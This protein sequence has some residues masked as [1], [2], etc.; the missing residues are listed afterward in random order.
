MLIPSDIPNGQVAEVNLFEL[1]SVIAQSNNQTTMT[2][3]CVSPAGGLV[4]SFR[5]L[6]RSL[7]HRTAVCRL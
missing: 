4:L 1:S 5:S 2:E 6:M 3:K 7:Y